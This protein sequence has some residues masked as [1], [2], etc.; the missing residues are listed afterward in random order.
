MLV[1]NGRP[2]GKGAFELSAPFIGNKRLI[3]EEPF[4]LPVSVNYKSD[5]Q[6]F[7]KFLGMKGLKSSTNVRVQEI[8]N[9]HSNKRC[10]LCCVTVYCALQSGSE[11]VDEIPKHF[12][13]LPS[14]GWSV[15]TFDSVNEILKSDHS[16]KNH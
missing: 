2:R 9:D 16:N 7:L 1:L 6:G 15:V 3:R 12:A 11:S 10:L 5:L 14:T 8:K 4:N 13:V